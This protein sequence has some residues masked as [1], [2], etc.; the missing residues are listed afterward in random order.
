MSRILALD[1]STEAC[2][3]ALALDGVIHA[4]FAIMP[5][6]HAQNILLMIRSLLDTH[7]LHFSDLDA[8]AWGRGPGSFTGLRIAAG[9]TQ[10][11]AFAAGLPVV[12]V[13]TLAALALQHHALHGGAAILSCLDARI[14][15]V[16]WAPYVMRE[17]EPEL[18]GEER[19]TAPEH[20][21]VELLTQVFACSEVAAAGSG[22][23]YKDRFPP[24][25]QA[26]L[27]YETPELLPHAAAIAQLAI[28]AFM[29][30]AVVTADAVEP[31]Y[32]RDKVT[33]SSP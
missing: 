28:T 29:R 31:L 11:I 30:G 21:P 18:V 12:P 8:I 17:G 4:D 25:I 32:L 26:L 24:A 6:Q 3:C 9:V 5:R 7:G 14:D 2:S 27:R 33:H 1:T 22:L 20:L 23:A 15:E 16:Y 10:G 19:L 13:S